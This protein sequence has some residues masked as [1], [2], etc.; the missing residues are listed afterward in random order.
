M[1]KTMMVSDDVYEDLKREKKVL[2]I[3]LGGY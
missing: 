2:A 3:S 1:P